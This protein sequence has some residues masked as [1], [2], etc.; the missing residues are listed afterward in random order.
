MKRKES[1]KHQEIGSNINSKSEVENS[2]ENRQEKILQATKKLV[3]KESTSNKES[4]KF[5]KHK[6]TCCMF[7]RVQKHGIHGPSIHGEDLSNFGKEVGNVCNQ[8]N[9]F[10]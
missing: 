8:C 1:A 4:I 3:A 2:Q 5:S 6:E 7:T 10:N 9:I